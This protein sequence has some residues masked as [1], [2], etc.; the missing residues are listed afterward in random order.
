MGLLVCVPAWFYFMFGAL[1]LLGARNGWGVVSAIL[2]I[3]VGLV[4]PKIDKGRAL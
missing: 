1:E 2:F 3:L 4:S